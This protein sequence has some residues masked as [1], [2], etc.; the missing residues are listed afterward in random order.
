MANFMYDKALEAFAQAEINLLT[1]N[2]KCIL[3][4]ATVYIASSASDQYFAIV[5]S[6]AVIATSPNLSGKSVTAGCFSAAGITFSTVTGPTCQAM[7]IYKDTGDPATSPLI[8]YLDTNYTNLPVIPN[9]GNV[10][11]SWPSGLNKIFKL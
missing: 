4:D 11:V 5:P 8:C 9:G 2:I 7:A 3:V 10:D 6:L 1:D